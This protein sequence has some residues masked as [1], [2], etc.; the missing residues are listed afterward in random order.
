MFHRPEI[1]GVKFDIRY[2]L[3]L[4]S[5]KPLKVFAYDRFWLR[6]ANKEFSLDNYDVYEK[7]FTVMNYNDQHLE[8]MFCHDFIKKFEQ[9]YPSFEWK[10][11]EKKIFA[12]FKQVFEAATS[13]D[14]PQGIGNS[15]Q[16]RAMYACDLMLKWDKKEIVPQILEIN[17]GPDCKRATEY[18]PEYFND[19]FY[20]L[21]L[22]EPRNAT[23]L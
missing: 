20:T 12:M 23:L 17:W 11:I 21:Y 3:L 14:P 8:Q 15:P 2:I 7:H 10:E 1:G 6:F 22:D 18:Y 13:L 19:V 9:Q 16:S 4:Q 5:T